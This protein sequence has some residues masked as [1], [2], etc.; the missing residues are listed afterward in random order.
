[1]TALRVNGASHE[2]RR[3]LVV[4]AS[5][6][7]LLGASISPAQAESPN[8]DQNLITAKT[9][10]AASALQAARQTHGFQVQQAESNGKRIKTYVQDRSDGF[11]VIARMDKA[12]PVRFENLL[13]PGQRFEP[14]QGGGL[15][16]LEGDNV[17]ASVDAPWASDATGRSLTTSYQIDGSTIVQ[18]VDTAGA[19]FPVLADRP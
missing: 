12:G 1:M 17:V 15:V 7:V 6:A 8:L 13:K 3:A 19:T 2:L 4:A 14:A 10:A 9:G 18:A 11:A 5:L 16:I